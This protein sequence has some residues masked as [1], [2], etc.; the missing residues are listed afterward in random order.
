MAS[1]NIFGDIS[2]IAGLILMV[3]HAKLVFS[4]L[5]FNPNLPNQI[6]W[7]KFIEPTLWN[8]IHQTK[9]TKSIEM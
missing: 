1:Y 9:S 2:T 6:Y 7:T 4:L 3:W 8:Q 5:A